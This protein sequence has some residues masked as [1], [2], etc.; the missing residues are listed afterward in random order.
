MSTEPTNL[1]G[2]MTNGGA[3]NSHNYPHLLNHPNFTLPHQEERIAL[4][5]TTIAYLKLSAE[6]AALQYNRGDGGY[7]G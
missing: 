3:Q 1:S 5:A 6:G 7:D 4:Q 2:I